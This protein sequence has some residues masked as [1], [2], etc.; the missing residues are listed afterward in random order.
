MSDETSTDTSD[1]STVD[2]VLRDLVGTLAPTPAVAM[3]IDREGRLLGASGQASGDGMWT[4]AFLAR[5]LERS[6]G[7]AD[8]LLAGE[9][10]H[11]ACDPHIVHVRLISSRALLVLMLEGAAPPDPTPAT[12]SLSPALDAALAH[13]PALGERELRELFGS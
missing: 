13:L 6:A 8:R 12:A 1:Q 10:V 7:L 3:L 4:A 2:V 5:E 11:V 9:G